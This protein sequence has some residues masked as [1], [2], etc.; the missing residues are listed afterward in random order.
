MK[1]VK[2]IVSDTCKTFT[3]QIRTYYMSAREEIPDDSQASAYGIF[4]TV[5]WT[6]STVLVCCLVRL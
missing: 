4:P 1:N 5:I 2:F 6:S 3:T